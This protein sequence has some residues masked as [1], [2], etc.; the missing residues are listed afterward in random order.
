MPQCGRTCLHVAAMCDDAATV[1]VLLQAGASAEARLAV[2]GGRRRE[3]QEGSG[4]PGGC[5]LECGVW[6]GRHGVKY[7][8]MCVPN[9]RAGVAGWACAGTWVVGCRRHGAKGVCPHL[10][11]QNGKTALAM[12]SEAGHA[13]AVATLLRHGADAGAQMSVRARGRDQGTST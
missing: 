13:A 10:P 7:R 11:R 5:A 6:G 9:L 4:R 8:M 2:S 1:E 3:L 12:A